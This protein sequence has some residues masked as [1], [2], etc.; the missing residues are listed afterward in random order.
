MED[1]IGS[2]LSRYALRLALAGDRP[3]PYALHV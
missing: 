2:L 3:D 1:G